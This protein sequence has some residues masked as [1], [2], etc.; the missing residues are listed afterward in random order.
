M[1]ITFDEFKKHVGIYKTP[2]GIFYIDPAL[3]DITFTAS[4]KVSI[5]E[6]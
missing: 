2:G 4:G 1:G 6:A 3:L 5:I